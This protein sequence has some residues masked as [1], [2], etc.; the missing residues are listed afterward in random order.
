MF[1]VLET[2][3]NCGTVSSKMVAN[4]SLLKNKFMRFFHV[5]T[6][7]LLFQAV[8]ASAQT[9]SKE[10]IAVSLNNH[11]KAVRVF[12]GTMRDPF[13]TLA[14]DGFY[15]LSSTRPLN[16]FPDELPGIQFF[17][18]SDLIDW[19]K[20]SPVWEAKNSE[21]G[22]DLIDAAS[23]RNIDAGI[24]APEAH[25]INGKWVI[26]NTSNM[27]MANIMLTQGTDLTGPFLTDSYKEPTEKKSSYAQNFDHRP[28]Q[29]GSKEATSINIGF[30]RDPSVFMD[31]DKTPWLISGAVE[32]HK[33]K[34]DFS[35]FDDYHKL[36]GPQ[37]R[38][39]GHEGAYITKVGSKYVLFGTAWSTDNMRK[40]SYNLYY[41]V[42]DKVTG[43]YGPRK[44]AGRFL[45]H[46]T[47]FQDKSGRWWCTAFYNAD[48][49][50]LTAEQA[51][52]M[53]LSKSAYTINEG[54]LTL[55]PM[56]IYEENGDVV[57]RAKDEAYRYPG[58]DEAQK[59]N[60][61]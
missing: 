42:A 27:R 30:H 59:F 41:C 17:R 20:L 53:D 47:P 39:L 52:T 51:A 46:G 29:S 40:G 57:V 16:T 60:L 24:W 28:A 21:Y 35:G 44:F 12:G 18:S 61:N 5:L 14:P 50:T 11:D 48:N 26:V 37:D 3:A 36:I 4:Y 32:I 15:Y 58:K 55:V 8:I 23:K 38:I 56:E 43:P 2:N 1:V 33:M 45:G 13:V 49:P 25:F 6:T 19:E 22:R 34:Q 9:P 54:G 7:L 31:D 10:S